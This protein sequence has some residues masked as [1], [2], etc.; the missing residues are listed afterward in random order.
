M[1]RAIGFDPG[2]ATTG[3]GVV[4]LTDG[5]LRHVAHGTIVTPA[6]EEMPARLVCLY[7]GVT[8]LL[9]QYQPS[10]VCVE[11]LFFK[12]NVTNGITVAQARGVILLAA[13]RQGL[14]IGEFSPTEAKTAVTGYGRADKHQMQEMTRM[15]LGLD[16]RPRPDDAADALALAICILQNRGK[17]PF[18]SVRTGRKVLR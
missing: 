10:L 5:R 14:H 11:R 17:L 4:E 15:L 2:T 9:G 18:Q 8:D 6:R 1:L 7:D 16:E 12:Q 13:A 3:W